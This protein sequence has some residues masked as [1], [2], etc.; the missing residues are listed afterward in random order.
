MNMRPRKRDASEMSND[1]TN[2]SNGASRYGASNGGGYTNGHSNGGDLNPDNKRM[3]RNR[4][5]DAAPEPKLNGTN[6]RY[7]NGSSSNT[8]GA[9]NGY[10][11]GVVNGSSTANGNGY[12]S[13]YGGDLMSQLSMAPPPPPPLP[14]GPSSLMGSAKGPSPSFAGP[15]PPPNYQ[16]FPGYY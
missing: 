7:Q 9:S 8:N 12:P 5:D 1:Y 13:V 2:G 16:P 4:W 14:V 6:P 10:S 15:M 3:R 11:N